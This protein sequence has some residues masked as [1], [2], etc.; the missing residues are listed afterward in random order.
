MGGDAAPLPI[1]VF[2]EGGHGS[3][4]TQGI[5]G[6]L[7]VPCHTLSPQSNKVP[8]VQHAH[9]MHPLT[10]LI[11][12]SNEP[13]PPGS[14]PGHLSPEIDPK[15]GELG[16]QDTSLF[17]EP[18]KP[19]DTTSGLGEQRERGGAGNVLGI[20]G[21]LLDATSASWM[22]STQSLGGGWGASNRSAWGVGIPPGFHS[23]RFSSAQPEVM[24][25][26]GDGL[27]KERGLGGKWGAQRKGAGGHGGS[28]AVVPLF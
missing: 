13:F 26:E 12:Y 3:P 25:A 19:L 6:W 20:R 16:L 17:G 15:T 27:L 1:G 23:G 4:A 2:L 24:G 9:H 10:P 21:Y 14:P 8:V 22:V 18:N 28:E 11:T 7:R 5:G